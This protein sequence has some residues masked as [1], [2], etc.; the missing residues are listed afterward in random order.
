MSLKH[1]LRAR[2][3]AGSCLCPFC[4]VLHEVKQAISP[5][6]ALI[7]L[8]CESDSSDSHSCIHSL[9]YPLDCMEQIKTHF[10]DPFEDSFDHRTDLTAVVD[11]ELLN[12][13]FHTA[14]PVT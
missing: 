9:R 12:G 6:A 14:E 8:I 7:G 1:D 10:V 5:M 4:T 11:P 2:M 13:V 3:N